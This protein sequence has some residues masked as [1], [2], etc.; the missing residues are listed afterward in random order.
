MQTLIIKTFAASII[1]MFGDPVYYFSINS[2]KDHKKLTG[3]F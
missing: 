2:R 1:F 3:F